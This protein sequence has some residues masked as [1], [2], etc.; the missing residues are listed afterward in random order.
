M[1]P[2]INFTK[3]VRYELMLGREAT[4][5][6]KEYPV[7][8]LPTGCLERH[9]DHLPMGLDVIKAHGICCI[10]AQAIGGVVFP[11]HFYSG[12]HKLNDELMQR[13]TSKWGNLYTDKTAMDNLKEIIDQI[14]VIGVKV[15]V[16]YSGH[17]P[18]VQIDMIKDIASEY[19]EK[20]LISII[21]AT[22]VDCLGEGDHAGIS[23]TSL[24]LYLDRNLVDMTRIGQLNYQD[25]GWS[26]ER[27]PERASSAKGESDIQKIIDYLGSR[28]KE[29]YDNV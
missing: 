21:P 2:A 14:I 24:M 13:F 7:A 6:I 18:S 1:N 20:G 8:Y 9:G 11:P 19:N 29:C 15:L 17:Y 26:E 23:E 16:L 10:V 22:D 3:K 25:H 12:I 27:S 28:I 5:R 4:Q